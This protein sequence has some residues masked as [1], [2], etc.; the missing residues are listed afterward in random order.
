MCLGIHCSSNICTSRYHL[1]PFNKLNQHLPSNSSKNQIKRCL[2]CDTKVLFLLCSCFLL[3]LNKQHSFQ[4][5]S[6]QLLFLGDEY[7]YLVSSDIYR[8]MGLQCQPHTLCLHRNSCRKCMMNH[9]MLH[10]FN[11]RL[12]RCHMLHFHSQYMQARQNYPEAVFYLCQLLA[13]RMSFQ[14][15]NYRLSLAFSL[16]YLL[17]RGS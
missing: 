12:S 1:L 16:T 8:R 7:I 4:M 10:M 13:A 17:C 11:T 2:Y 6:H 5:L 15:R 9:L 3:L 14:L